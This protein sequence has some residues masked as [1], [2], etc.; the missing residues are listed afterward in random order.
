MKI[1]ENRFKKALLSGRQQYGYWL[2]LCNSISAELC[3]HVGFD[4][5]LIDAEHAPNDLSTIQTQLLAIDNT[6]SQAVVRIV[7]GRAALI[8]Q[9]LDLGA[10]TILVPMVETAEQARQLV[11]DV[12][13]PPKGNRGVGTAI[14]RAA[15][16]NRVE[17][18][19]SDADAQICLLIQVE[20][21]TALDNLTEILEVEGVHGVFIGPADLA[22]SMGYLGK[23]SHPEVIA[24]IE[25]AIQA[26]AKS[27]KAAGILATD[28]NLAKR[29]ETQGAQFLALGVDTVTLASGAAKILATHRNDADASDKSTDSSGAY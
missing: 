17:N 2:G 14:A 11:E 22:G 26:I 29:Y 27:D 24:R 28:P 3:G 10:Q 23:P 16:W 19:L 12:H 6:P 15:R 25:A 20:S 21:V 5:L 7:E 4:W 1:P 13:Y 18:Y 9:V 8:K